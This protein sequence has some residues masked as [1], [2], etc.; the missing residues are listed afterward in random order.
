VIV[1]LNNWVLNHELPKFN[2]SFPKSA[3]YPE[4]AFKEQI[5]ASLGTF[6]E[7]YVCGWCASHQPGTSLIC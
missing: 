1:D 6:V 3:P 7:R 2:K 4:R 5:E